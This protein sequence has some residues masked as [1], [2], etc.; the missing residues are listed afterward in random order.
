MTSR[1]R[2]GAGARRRALPGLA[3]GLAAL[4]SSGSAFAE[5]IEDALVAAYNSNPDLQA[6]RARLRA[7]DEGVPQARAGW[8]PT[9]TINASYGY[10]STRSA[11]PF[12]S[13]IGSKQQVHPSQGDLT[14][15]QPLFTSGRTYYSVRQAKA[16]VRA[17]RADLRASEQ[18][19]LVN[20][21]SAFMNVIR[22]QSILEL[23]HNNL[24]VL[25]RQ[26]QATRDRFQ[27]GELT[28]TDV[29]QAEARLANAA[30]SLTQAEANLTVSRSNY[31]TVIGQAPGSLTAPTS[32]PPLPSAEMDALEIGL[33]ENPSLVGARERETASRF[34]IAV[35][36]GALG[37]TIDLQAQL[38]HAEDNQI[39]GDQSD[40]KSIMAQIRIPLYQG[41]AE[42]SRVRQAKQVNSQSLATIASTERQ[43]VE[44]IANAWEGLRA[45]RA[46][47]DSGKEQVR[48]NQVA[49]EGVQQEA[50][51]GSRT[52][53]DVLNAEQEL[54]N[55]QVSLVGAQRNEVVAAY[56]LISAIGR[57]SAEQLALPAQ[58]YDS[59]AYYR[60]V[61][62][63][64]VGWDV[65]THQ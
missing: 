63:K 8:L 54:L 7:V 38:A 20:A 48:S 2:I 19:I 49:F 14:I 1:M 31:Q 43:V 30:S 24:D 61:N 41:G 34:A 13:F 55:A 59:T 16:D 65:R 11:S 60:K 3:L 53:L 9:I 15:V 21:V 33:Q 51:V 10:T 62:F 45:A 56:Q 39:K 28:R 12:A 44:G 40:S 29:A 5:T 50:K 26:L 27:V 57:L 6:A 4:L 58:P 23:N 46:Q 52:T 18:Q 35:A 47:T 64:L 37:P 42:W 32:L 22:D 25:K 17:G 36:K